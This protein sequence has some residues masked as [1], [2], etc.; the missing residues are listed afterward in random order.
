MKVWPPASEE[1]K[2]WYERQE[3]HPERLPQH[4]LEWVGHGW[5]VKS[6]P[7]LEPQIDAVN[8]VMDRVVWPQMQN[9]RERIGGLH[10]RCQEIANLFG[11]PSIT[12]TVDEILGGHSVPSYSLMFLF[13]SEQA[14]HQDEA[15]FHSWPPRAFVGAWFTLEDIDPASGPLLVASGS[16]R[17]AYPW[18]NYPQTNLRTADAALTASYRLWM[19]VAAKNGYRLETPILKKGDVLFWHPGLFHGGSPIQ[20]RS[21][22]RKSMVAHYF[23]MGTNK[24]GEIEGP[25]NWD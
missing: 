16:H 8:A 10:G 15:V 12:R 5:F 24:A 21:L 17:E 7:H 1:Q 22:T 25:L 23:A 2:P 11:N 9:P 20:N 19:D 3:L 14:L 4:L 18:P 6:F 13:G